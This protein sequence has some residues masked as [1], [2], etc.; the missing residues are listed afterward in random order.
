[1]LYIN[2]GYGICI[3]IMGDLDLDLDQF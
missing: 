2:S 3:R 1:M